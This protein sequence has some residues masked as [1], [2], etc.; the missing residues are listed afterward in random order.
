[1]KSEV[2]GQRLATVRSSLNFTQKQVASYL[3]TQRETI[4]YIESGARPITTGTLIK[5]ADLY[6]Y[7]VSYFLNESNKDETPNVSIA[8]RVT[9]LTDKDLGTIAEV[10][11]IASNLCSLYK[12]L[13][14][15][16]NA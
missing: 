15:S 2:I 11:R 5:L 4:S 16:H 7:K 3:G 8:F 6:G 10:K 12:L 1:M 9:D 13:G 14:I